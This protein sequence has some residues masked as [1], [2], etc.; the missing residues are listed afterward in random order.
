MMSL[1]FTVAPV[2]TEL[3]VMSF[4]FAEPVGTEPTVAVSPEPVTRAAVA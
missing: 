4:D 3:I 1:Y 2:V